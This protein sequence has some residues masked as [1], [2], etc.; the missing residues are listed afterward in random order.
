MAVCSLA[1]TAGVCIIYG[2]VSQ[3]WLLIVCAFL[4]GACQ[5]FAAPMA[6]TALFENS[7]RER[8]SEAMGLRMSL[9]M[10]CQFVL[11]LLAGVLASFV[12]V[13]A[14]FWVVGVAMLAGGWVYRGYWKQSP[15]AN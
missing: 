6:Q 2:L 10:A 4:M 7:P 8:Y 13:L 9:G 1:L 3:V 15:K 11:P 12:G 14:I 5:S